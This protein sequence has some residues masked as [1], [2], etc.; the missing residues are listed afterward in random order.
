M[1]LYVDIE[2]YSEVDLP[3]VGVYRYAADPSF[4][5]LVAAWS[6]DDG[7]I[8]V[9]TK[10]E[11]IPGLTD[12]EVT[13]VAH[14]AMFERVCFTAYLGLSSYLPPQ[15]W[16]DTAAVASELGLPAS[17]E[18]LALALGAEPKDSAGKKLIRLFSMPHKGVRTT[19]Y[20]KPDEWMDFVAYCVQD[21]STMVDCDRRMGG[22]PTELERQI[23]CADQLVND[24]GWQVDRELAEK[25][26]KLDLHNRAELRRE[27]KVLTELKNPGSNVQFKGWLEEQGIEIPDLR[28]STIAQALLDLE[29]PEQKKV[30]SLY[31]EL[32]QRATGKYEI[33]VKAMNNDN[34]VRGTFK[35]FGAH[36]GRWAGKGVQ[37]HNFPRTQYKGTNE[38]EQAIAQ[39]KHGGELPQRDLKKL[40]RSMFQGPF[41][42]V[43]YSAIEARVIA[44]LAG[45]RWVL[46]SA[47]E[48]RDLYLE[49]AARMGNA[50][51]LAGKIAT[52][53][54]GFGGSV[55]SLRAMMGGVYTSPE[56]VIKS[57]GTLGAASQDL[58]GLSKPS[59]EQL[60]EV[61]RQWRKANRR[62]V[63]LWY[64]LER[65]FVEG[66]HVG[67]KLRVE[68][69]EGFANDCWNKLW[70]PSGRYIGYHHVKDLS[71]KDLRFGQIETYGGR[72]SENATQAVARDVL[73]EAIVRLQDS[74]YVVVA[75]VHDEIIVEGAHEP[76]E[77]QRIVCESPTWARG[78][79]ITATGEVQQRYR[80]G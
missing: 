71:F 57:Y 59:D 53:A 2:T 44:W 10:P 39:L 32:A 77:I 12:P 34:R 55:G 33:A 21:V 8:Q 51:R 79:P 15:Q 74:G 6:V 3:R 29:D 65:A 76:Q 23:W 4:R 16:H 17:L 43:D 37:P 36:T 49:A 19:P 31:Q 22:F 73:A 41:T 11:T 30:L 1:K 58:I 75:H 72:L 62:I 13:K 69:T 50:S 63:Q 56:G 61:V 14:N 60:L 28:T 52:L 42:V 38:E 27:L 68:R 64:D 9:T 67:K 7:P 48:G 24:A 45:E 25:A 78:L 26:V 70:L 80:K 47:V 46:E 18:K 20:E 66:G 54:L 5:I 40:T 35:F